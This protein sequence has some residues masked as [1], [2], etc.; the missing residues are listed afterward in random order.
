MLDRGHTKVIYEALLPH[1]LDP[2]AALG[3]RHADLGWRS[4]QIRAGQVHPHQG[5]ASLE[6]HGVPP[7][8]SQ[9]PALPRKSDRGAFTSGW[10]CGCSVASLRAG[11]VTLTDEILNIL[12]GL[13]QG[14]V[15]ISETISLNNLNIGLCGR[16]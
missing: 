6:C 5:A 13:Q 11:S 8:Q 9:P 15:T 3:N 4:E 1:V 10:R 14:S 12:Q 2:D 7:A 16:G